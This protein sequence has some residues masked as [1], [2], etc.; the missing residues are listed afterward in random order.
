MSIVL[1]RVDGRL[2]HGQ[3]AVAWSKEVKANK[4]VIIDEDTFND[5]MGKSL[6]EL[7]APT[8]VEVK[9]FGIDKGIEAIKQE[10]D[11]P[12]NTILIVKNLE[13]ILVLINSGIT[14]N[15][16]NIGGMYYEKGKKKIDKALFINEQ[17]KNDIKKLKEKGVSMFYQVAPMTKKKDI[18]SL[19]N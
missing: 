11:D 17:D 10:K 3:V 14:L 7:A 8:N 9:V 13:T 6:I 16:I 15:K 1:T 19:I 2:L 5:E 4:I 12:N 18:F